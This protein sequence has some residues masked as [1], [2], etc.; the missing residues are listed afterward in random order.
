MNERRE[1]NVISEH[2]DQLLE[3]D[4]YLKDLKLAFEYQ[5]LN[6]HTF[7]CLSTLSLA[8]SSFLQSTFHRI[9]TITLQRGTIRNQNKQLSRLMISLRAEFFIIIKL[10]CW[11]L[12]SLFL[13]LLIDMKQKAAS[14]QGISLIRVPCWW[15][16]SRHR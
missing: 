3:L 16:G 8:H 5:V 1:G 12:K 14:G 7:L 10:D 11:F 13:L 2:T 15:D 6:M 4:F 9:H